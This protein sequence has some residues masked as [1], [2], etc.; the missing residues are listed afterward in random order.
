MLAQEIALRYVVGNRRKRVFC[1]Q[2]S[3]EKAQKRRLEALQ[4]QN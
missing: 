1:M 3:K 4:A 2:T